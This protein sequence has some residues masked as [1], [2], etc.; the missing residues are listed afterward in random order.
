MFWP[1]SIYNL[2]YPKERY[3]GAQVRILRETEKAKKLVSLKFT[4]KK[5]LLDST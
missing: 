2:I 4:L 1:F 5:A 3:I